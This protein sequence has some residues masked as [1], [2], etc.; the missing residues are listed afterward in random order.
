MQSELDFMRMA[1][2]ASRKCKG[3]DDRAHPKV[4]AV[5]VKNGKVLAVTY[6]G[7]LSDGEHAEYT[8]L[9]RKLADDVLAG[10][11]VYTTLEPC[12]SR[13]HPKV[14]CADRL[15]DRKV[16]RVVIG[17]L[18][19]NPDITGKG[20]RRLRDAN[21]KTDL[22]PADLMAEVEELNREF[23]RFQKRQDEGPTVSDALIKA[24]ISRSL[25][26]WYKTTNRIFWNQ[27]FQRDP[28][29]IF[30]HLVEVIGGLSAL[31]SS[32]RKAGVDPETYIVKAL[33]WWLALC[34]KLGI[35]S[36]EDMLWD[37]FPAVCP[38]CQESRHNPDICT[39]RKAAAG[40]PPWAQLATLGNK[41]QKPKRIREWQRM[42]STIYP[43][44]QTEEYGPSFARLT[45]ELGELAEAVRV[46][47]A[48]PGYLLSEAA[49]VFAWLM[50]IQNIVD[51][52]A[53]VPM[54]NRGDALE[55]A[56]ARA[57]PDSCTACGKRQCS[58]PPILPS[59]IGRI[60]HEVPSGRGSFN[61]VD[62]GRFMTPDR[63]SK[64]F[65]DM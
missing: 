12:T 52:R 36:V 26:D 38:Y 64:F 29:A 23:T 34:G 51:S 18:D 5:V 9:E 56:L 17:M 50:H 40:G 55:L 49:D 25:D 62:G 46:F 3:E 6:R 63:S 59:T 7:E 39:E 47:R 21:I 4:G 1:I 43:A 35:K 58:C 41:G 8:A 48:E 28:S 30:S 53:F 19:P 22:F 31:A 65:Q 57:Y 45:E 42:F 2:D 15:I 37:K 60:A 32:K 14:P 10:A 16:A 54:A 44:Q 61:D 33:A 24:N 13:N 27:N 20:Q 11:T